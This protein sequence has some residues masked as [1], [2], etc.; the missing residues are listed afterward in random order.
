MTI[1]TKDWAIFLTKFLE[2]CDSPILRDAGKISMLEAKLK[3]ESEYEKYRV[4]QDNL[5]ETD[6][7]RFLKQPDEKKENLHDHQ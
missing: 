6:F 7:D 1:S 3:A 5:F 4:V 2:L